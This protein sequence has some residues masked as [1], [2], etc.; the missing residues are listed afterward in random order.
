LNDI[1]LR[2][3]AAGAAL[4]TDDRTRL[5]YR[6]PRRLLAESWTEELAQYI[7]SF[8]ARLLPDEV[9]PGDL[10]S[11][12]LAAA[13]SALELNDARAV[14]WIA[15]VG[16]VAPAGRIPYLQGRLA[17]QQN[18]PQEAAKLLGKRFRKILTS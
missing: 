7:A 13:E 1:E 16:D 9:A 18:R 17:L 15:E 8:H 12:R 14:E 5:E 10:P 4:N 3:M 6:A 2:T 11:A